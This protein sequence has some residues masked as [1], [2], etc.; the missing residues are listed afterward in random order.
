MSDEYTVLARKTFERLCEWLEQQYRLG[1]E[2]LVL[3]AD[4]SVA[5]METGLALE[6][7]GEAIRA[8]Q[9]AP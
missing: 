6:A 4:A 7:W 1:G 2:C 9:E 3:D 8:R 5:L